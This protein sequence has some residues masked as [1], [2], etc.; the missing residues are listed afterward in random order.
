MILGLGTSLLFSYT[1]VGYLPQDLWLECLA[2][3]APSQQSKRDG[4]V[5]IVVL[6]NT[7]LITV[8]LSLLSKVNF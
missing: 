1:K 5:L 7:T 3:P 2:S 6:Q 8:L 4:F